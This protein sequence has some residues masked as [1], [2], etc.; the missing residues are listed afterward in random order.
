[1]HEADA[2][3]RDIVSLQREMLT[4]LKAIRGILAAEA[5]GGGNGAARPAPAGG[6]DLVDRIMALNRSRQQ[7]AREAAGMDIVARKG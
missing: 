5:G 6:A 2:I 3:L 7:T 1:M 4:E